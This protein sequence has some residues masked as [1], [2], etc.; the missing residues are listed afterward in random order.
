MPQYFPEKNNTLKYSNNPYL[1]QHA[2]N[3]VHWHMWE[4]QVLQLAKHEDKPL[5]ISI[6][7]STCHWCHVMARESFEDQ[8]IAEILNSNFVSIKIDREERPDIDSFYMDI[9]VRLNGSGG[10]PLTVI[11]TP[12]GNPFFI[13]T[14]IPKNSIYGKTGLMELLP[15]ISRIWR[16]ERERVYSSS[17]S[18]IDALK[19][20]R[21]T[22]SNKKE[23]EIPSLKEIYQ[24]LQTTYDQ[25]NGGFGNAPKF[26]Q[27]HLLL[28]LLQNSKEFQ[29][30]GEAVDMVEHTL[31]K[32]R[33]GGIYDHIGFG[34]H[35]YA[36]DKKWKVPHFEKMLYDQAMLSQTYT[37]AYM[38]TGNKSYAEIAGEIFDF[39]M[40]EMHAPE[41]G[42]Y[43]AIDA[44]SED[45]E[46]KFYLWKSDEFESLLSEEEFSLR[47]IF[48]VS[49]QG[50]WVDPVSSKSEASNILYTCSFETALNPIV[51]WSDVRNRLYTHRSYRSTPMVDDKI[52]TSWNALMIKAFLRAGFFWDEQ[53]YI[54]IAEQAF[55][56]ILN[57][58]IETVDESGA[59]QLLHSYRSGKASVPAQFEDYAYLIAAI[60]EFYNVNYNPEYLK[61]AKEYTDKALDIF[62]DHENGG[63]YVSNPAF[64]DVPI[65]NKIIF[66]AAVPSA[67]S[68][69]VENLS[70]LFRITG[71]TQYRN[72]ALR[73]YNFH[74][75]EIR[76]ST[77]GATLL[78]SA[79]HE[80]TEQNTGFEVV[81]VGDSEEAIK[82]EAYVRHS[83]LPHA[84]ILRKK[85]DIAEALAS[86]APATENYT[87]D[88]EKGASA[89]ICRGGF[90][91]KPIPTLDAL[92]EKL[93]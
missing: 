87:V 25:K 61:Q 77:L 66:D 69:M 3:P 62:E 59:K 6:G 5:F 9:A 47:E 88:P 92:K 52:L 16:D 65:R 40:N 58:M 49:D 30:E 24:Q 54:E 14:Y 50:N 35:R 41:G 31:Q 60:I 64:T 85:S 38:S 28:F 81:I 57:K 39:V 51:N 67:T 43:S 37:E 4:K 68:I 90:C 13:S 80:I 8:E 70:K 7:Y 20:L 15:E 71:E 89:Y 17:N 75:T 21:K 84:T 72:A 23:T 33:S 55:A 46:G 11:A 91:E 18:I 32:M 56:F 73:A 2:D 76:S 42:F 45:E 26:P 12:E 44:E 82:M 10:W 63:F 74:E 27:P 29:N 48:N 53:N 78:L 86:V 34:F 19:K 1:L 83:F 79:L 36:T 22:K 93:R